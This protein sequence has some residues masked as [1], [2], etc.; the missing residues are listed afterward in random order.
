MSDFTLPSGRTL[1]FVKERP[2]WGDFMDA[3]DAAALAEKSGRAVLYARATLVAARLTGLPEAE[4]RALDAQDG[5][6]LSAEAIRRM[7][8]RS[9]EDT[10]PFSSAPSST[11]T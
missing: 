3:E 6:A 1:Q 7:T 11:S 8:P 4:I 5:D 2:T 9:K 10:V